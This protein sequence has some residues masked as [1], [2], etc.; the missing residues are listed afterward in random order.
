MMLLSPRELKV[1]LW[2]VGAPREGG[3]AGAG[4]G[5]VEQVWSRGYEGVPPVVLRQ[6]PD[7]V[8]LLWTRTVNARGATLER[9]NA[10]DGSTVYRT[11]PF[12][13]LFP[14]DEALRRRVE[15]MRNTIETPQDGAVRLEDVLTAM[16]GE[17]VVM[18]ERTG[19]MAAFERGTGTVLWAQNSAVIQVY[20]IALSGGVLAI[21]GEAATEADPQGMAALTPLISM[22]DARSGKEVHKLDQIKGQV[23]WVRMG[24]GPTQQPAL[25]AGLMPEVVS[26]DVGSGKVNWTVTGG[27][28]FASTDAWVF[29]DRIFLL[30]QARDL[31]LIDGAR[32]VMPEAA[33]ATEG[34]LAGNGN[35]EGMRLGAERF[36]FSTEMGVC[37]YDGTGRLIGIDPLM[38][39]TGETVLISPVAAAS[40]YVAV[41]MTPQQGPDQRVSYPLHILDNTSGMLRS[42]R[43][44]QLEMPPKR[45]TVLDGRVAVTC[46]NVTLVYEAP[47]RD[48]PPPARGR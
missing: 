26:F 5:Q 47:E 22:V 46:G 10:V 3:A 24:V 7:S 19:R 30:D 27:A 32:G 11:E 44:L 48:E 37:I 20:D 45:V 6:D 41:E 38:D 14:E 21:G 23:R 17:T 1:A 28:A 13:T 29:G 12:R 40:H 25:I 36:G 31:Y 8:Y 18:V 34:R 42:S 43:G 16:D 2:G 15:L 35:I 9:V 4:R 33:L 39:Q